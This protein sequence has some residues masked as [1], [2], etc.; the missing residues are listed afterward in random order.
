MS[1]QKAKNVSFYRKRF[2]PWLLI[3]PTILILFTI[4][5]YPLIYI[6]RLSVFNLF[7]SKP[8]VPLEFIGINNFKEI[9]EDA[10][11]FNSI[12]VTVMFTGLAVI[13]EFWLGLGLAMMARRVKGGTVFRTFLIIPM[14]TTPVIV[15]LAWRFMLFPRLGVVAWYIQRL[16]QMFGIEIPLLLAN[17]DIALFTV[18]AVD[19]W[20]WTPFM[21]LILFAG[22]TSLHKE[23]FEAA[24]VD[25]A[26]GW[27][28]FRTIT[29]PLLKPVILI[30]LL[31]RTVDAF[32]TFDQIYV[33]TGGGPGNATDTLSMYLYR[34]SFVF[35]ST[36]KGAALAL[37]MLLVM[38]IFSNFFIKLLG[39]KVSV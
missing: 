3:S 10:Q 24:R 31:I 2:F 39:K 22:L 25:G 33:L 29:L 17:P 18:I 21:F 9:L 37:L 12:R 38:L 16:G 7:L 14:V 34:T 5:I 11:F 13:I 6:L 28:I 23:P 26:S 8:W 20:E 4:G 32:N 30:C 36:S 35:F 15:G 1:K 27:R 19:I